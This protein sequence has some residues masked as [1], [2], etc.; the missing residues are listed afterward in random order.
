MCPDMGGDEWRTID[1][2]CDGETAVALRCTSAMIRGYIGLATDHP[3]ACVVVRFRTH[4]LSHDRQR[5]LRE[6]IQKSSPDVI[7]W[8][9]LQKFSW[10][11]HT[12][13]VK[14]AI[15]RPDDI[16]VL[17]VLVSWLSP[18]IPITQV[19][20]D[21]AAHCGKWD[22][23]LWLCEFNTLLTMDAWTLQ[24]AARSGRAQIVDHLLRLQCPVTLAACEAAAAAGDL[25]VLSRFHDIHPEWGG[26]EMHE[27]ARAGHLHVVQWLH[28]RQCPWNQS[29]YRIAVAR[30]FIELAKW[31]EAHGCPRD[32]EACLRKIPRPCPQYDDMFTFLSS[33]H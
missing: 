8:L 24:T 22:V 27:A 33:L 28:E 14:L 19:A 11:L 9:L 4:P 7:Q 32:L 26:F 31:L 6:C 3:R 23:M 30:N 10:T 29:V 16:Q 20:L 15:E 17:Q 5:T 21:F 18:A 12:F 1:A 25:H 2:L 13:H